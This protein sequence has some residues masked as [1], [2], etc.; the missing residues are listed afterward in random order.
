MFHKILDNLYI[1]QKWN[2]IF[3]FRN[4]RLLMF[5]IRARPCKIMWQDFA[6]L[7]CTD[8]I[9]LRNNITLRSHFERVPN[10]FQWK[11]GE[12]RSPFWL[13]TTFSHRKIPTP[14]ETWATVGF[15]SWQ[16]WTIIL[17]FIPGWNTRPLW[18]RLKLD[19]VRAACIIANCVFVSTVH[20]SK[21]SGRKCFKSRPYHSNPNCA[22][23]RLHFSRRFNNT[24]ED[25]SDW[26]STGSNCSRPA[27]LNRYQP[28]WNKRI[29]CL[30]I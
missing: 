6:C 24:G 27:H 30:A 19:T 10:A 23:H 8:S 18:P 13:K 29:M 22:V 1:L 12:T 25:S 26:N 9:L 28:G 11:C 4:I 5:K 17:S 16:L 3:Q 2:S 21:S 20:V 7:F 15:D 14:N